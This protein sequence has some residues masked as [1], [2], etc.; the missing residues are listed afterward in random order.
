MIT[1]HISTIVIKIKDTFFLRKKD[2]TRYN[3]PTNPPSPPKVI[4]GSNFFSANN[5]DRIY[6]K[7]FNPA[8]QPNV[9][10]NIVGLYRSISKPVSRT[11]FNAVIK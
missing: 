1:Y 10:P 4:L 11:V 2:Y 3:T 5:L 7:I 8:I 6:G 9:I